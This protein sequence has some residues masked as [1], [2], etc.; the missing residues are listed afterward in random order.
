[1]KTCSQCQSSFEVREEDRAFYQ[2]MDVQE[3]T[4]CSNCRQRRRAMFRN[5]LNFYRRRCDFS[6]ADLISMYRPEIPVTVYSPKV[7]WSDQ[8]NPMDYGVDF[9]FSKSFFEQFQAL[10]KRVPR[11]SLYGKNNENSDYTNH[12]DHAKNCYMCADVGFSEDCFYSKWIIDCRD[13]V[14]SYQLEK[15]ERCYGSFYSVGAYDSKFIYLADNSQNADFL[16]NCKSVKNALMCWNLRQKEYYIE[17]KSYSKEAYLKALES[18]DTG[19]YKKLESYKDRYASLVRQAIRKPAEIINS[20]NCTGD[21]VYHSKNVYDSFGVIE[22][23]DSR[24]C[25]DSGHLKD[26][27]DTYES[28]FDCELQYESYA[29]NRGKFLMGCMVCYDVSDLFYSEMCHNSSDLFGCIGLRYK[30]YC[31]LNKQYSKEAYEALLPKIIA[32]LKQTGEWGEFFPNEMTFF[33]YNES[34]APEFFPMTQEAVLGM[35]WQW[36]EDEKEYQLQTYQIPDHINEVSDSIVNEVLA[37]EKCDKNYRIITK[38][39][40]FYQSNNLPIP[41]SCPLCRYHERLQWR[42]PYQ[43]FNRHCAKCSAEIQTSYAPDRPETVYCESCYLK[44]V[45]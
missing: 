23:Q 44:E 21:Y 45:Y 19:S 30:K 41:R 39:L 31:I 35:G 12:T 26:C 7:W 37:C 25:Y 4:L 11:L 16:Y 10:R 20:E 13:L 43:L 14:D 42:N 34:A 24:Y 28:A 6:G 36:Y 32:H 22:S 1:M 8:W 5:E 29:C 9:D 27:Y 18:Y 15:S 17:N 40:Q 2:R 33:A 3:P 38:E